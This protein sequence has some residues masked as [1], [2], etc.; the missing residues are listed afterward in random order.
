MVK[1]AETPAGHQLSNEKEACTGS[2]TKQFSIAETLYSVEAGSTAQG[3]RRNSV[4]HKL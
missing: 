1:S 2:K 3:Q 4:R